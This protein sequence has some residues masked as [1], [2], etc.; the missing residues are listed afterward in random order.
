MNPK[1]KIANDYYIEK[2]NKNTTKPVVEKNDTKVQE[3][4]DQA[5]VQFSAL[6]KDYQTQKQAITDSYDKRL[7]DLESE[8]KSSEDLQI[9]NQTQSNKD[10]SKKITKIRENL[11]DD[12]E[13]LMQQR[14]DALDEAEREFEMKSSKIINDLNSSILIKILWNDQTLSYQAML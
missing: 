1:D 5:N 4:I 2:Q 13:K 3:Q 14:A 8:A 6:S 10:L 9:R 11:K 12:K 7:A